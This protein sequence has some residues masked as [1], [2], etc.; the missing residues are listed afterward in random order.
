MNQPQVVSNKFP[1]LPSMGAYQE[2]EAQESI[3]RETKEFQI[4][5]AKR[6]EELGA[7]RTP[8]PD[9]L[10][11]DDPQS[12]QDTNQVPTSKTLN[13]KDHEEAGDELVQDQEDAV[14]Y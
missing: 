11:G 8:K 12:A 2:E 5:K 6:L 1:V 7:S 9:V 13:V 3:A 10:V 14:L 4:L